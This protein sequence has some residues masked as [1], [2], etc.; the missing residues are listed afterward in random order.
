MWLRFRY[1]YICIPK[2]RKHYSLKLVF[3]YIPQARYHYSMKLLYTVYT[4]GEIP[5]THWYIYWYI[6][7]YIYIYIYTLIWGLIVWSLRCAARPQPPHRLG[8]GELFRQLNSHRRAEG[9]ALWLPRMSQH[10][11]GL[12]AWKGIRVCLQCGHWKFS[13]AH[14]H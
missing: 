9:P 4:Y 2:L 3:I 13:Q 5:V 1:I 11:T 6:Y 14:A 8:V 10:I 12:D 7:I